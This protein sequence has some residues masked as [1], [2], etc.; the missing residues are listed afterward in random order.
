MS[1]WGPGKSSS[2]TLHTFVIPL[3]LRRHM[4]NVGVPRFKG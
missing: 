1:R 2:Q 3:L 4:M